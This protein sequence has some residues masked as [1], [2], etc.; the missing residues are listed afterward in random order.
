MYYNIAMENPVKLSSDGKPISLL[1]YDDPVHLG[2][3]EEAAAMTEKKVPFATATKVY[4]I[5]VF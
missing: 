5:N 1:Q 4:L 3:G 2:T